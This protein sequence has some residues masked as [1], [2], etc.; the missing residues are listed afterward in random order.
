MLWLGS[1]HRSP[2]QNPSTSVLRVSLVLSCSSLPSN[3]YLLV[4]SYHSS[5]VPP[6]GHFKSCAIAFDFLQ[7]CQSTGFAADRRQGCGAFRM[8]ATNCFCVR[9]SSFLPTDPTGVLQHTMFK[10][11]K[12]C[13]S[14]VFTE[15][16]SSPTASLNTKELGERL[17]IGP[18]G[19]FCAS[20]AP[21]LYLAAARMDLR[22]A[23]PRR[24]TRTSVRFDGCSMFSCVF[25]KSD[26][27][28][29]V[30]SSWSSSGI[31]FSV[32]F[33]L[34][35]R[36]CPAGN[37]RLVM[38]VAVVCVFCAFP[39]ILCTRFVLAIL[40]TRLTDSVDHRSA[41]NALAVETLVITIAGPLRT[42]TLGCCWISS[43]SSCAS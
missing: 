17:T 38:Y 2:L 28:C 10:A 14:Y 13:F 5:T 27:D 31:V 12:V 21:Q 29:S 24:D 4:L 34:S 19:R 40:T 15:N 37:R 35:S 39:L 16:R 32:R 7:I 18:A 9:S 8:I 33:P 26:K 25:K 11:G 1:R 23:P 43:R 42:N 41:S 36:P 30:S 3:P 20:Q 6:G 22:L